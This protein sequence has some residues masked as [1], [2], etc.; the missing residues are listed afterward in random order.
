MLTTAEI[1]QIIAGKSSV[2]QLRLIGEMMSEATDAV[3]R[4]LL[5]AEKGKVLWR[6]GRRGEAMTAYEEGAQLCPGGA[7]SVLLDHSRD[8]MDFFN[9]DL[10]NP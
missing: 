5:L 1:K 8:I 2:E 6:A 9:P 10:L 4:S 3:D 7:A